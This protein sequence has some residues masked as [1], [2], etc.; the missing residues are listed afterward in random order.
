[1][2]RIQKRSGVVSFLTGLLPLFTLAHFGHHVMMALLSPL[3]PFIRRDFFLSYT[4]AGG[5]ISAYSITYGISQLPAGLAAGRL[6][7]RN[8]LTIGVAGVAF[9]GFLI[10][11]SPNYIVM[12]LLLVVMGLVGGGY[13]PSAS[14]LL[15]ASVKPEHRGRALGIHQVGGTTSFFLAPLI[16]AGVASALGWRGTFMA[17]AIPTLSFGI[18]FHLLLGKMGYAGTAQGKE[19]EASAAELSGPGELRRL[20]AFIAIGIT[21]MVLIQSTLQ[22]IPLYAV[23]VLGASEEQGAALLSIAYFGGIL[24][25]PLGGYMSDR[26]GRIPVIIAVGLISGPAIYLLNHV[27]L[28]VS[29]YFVLLL[30]GIAMHAG[31]PVVESY[32]IGHVSPQKRSTVLGIYY[33]VSRGG[34]AIAFLLGYLIDTYQFF[35]TLS[36]VSIAMLA[37]AI[38]GMALLWGK[39]G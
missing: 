10:G 19:A 28:G 20:S 26:L 4:Q 35:I 27:S 29:L 13:H 24:G 9:T 37:V 33:M 3:L 6:G 11:L 8:L 14:P 7:S 18:I 31:M 21:S 30:L 23:D 16:V 34:L 5:L 17:T 25:G 15:S 2:K 39:R 12:V 22:F 32:I 1:M 36:G 38:V